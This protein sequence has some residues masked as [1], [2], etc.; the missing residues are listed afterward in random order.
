MTILA[1]S[2]D[3]Y[4]YCNFLSSFVM[5]SDSQVLVWK[6]NKNRVS[7]AQ[8]A[9]LTGTGRPLRKNDLHKPS[10]GWMETDLWTWWNHPKHLPET[11]LTYRTPT[12][13]KLVTVY[14]H[15]RPLKQLV[16]PYRQIL[17]HVNYNSHQATFSNLFFVLV[18]PWLFFFLRTLF[19]G[20]LNLFFLN[21]D[22]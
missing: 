19:Q 13:K 5:S 15:N 4:K 2:I 16:I 17:S 11:Q 6:E 3:Q 22:P 14:L 20:Y 9:H 7:M 1:N 18:S 12:L 8:I 21:C 10:L